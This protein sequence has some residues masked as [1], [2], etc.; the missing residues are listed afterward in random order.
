MSSKYYEKGKADAAKGKLDPPHQYLGP[1]WKT[2]K[3]VHEEKEYK[4]GRKAGK[5]QARKK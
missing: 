1:V 5:A 3:E 2:R 4:E